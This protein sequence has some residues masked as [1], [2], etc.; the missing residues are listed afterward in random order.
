MKL[1]RITIVNCVYGDTRISLYSGNSRKEAMAKARLD[2]EPY[3]KVSV[4]E[5][6]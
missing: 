1:F 4:C 3:E 5:E 6:L 2:I